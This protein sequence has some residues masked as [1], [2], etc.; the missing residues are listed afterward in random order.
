MSGSYAAS[1]VDYETL[2]AAKRLALGAA[3]A[4]ASLG[5][6]RGARLDA[7]FFGEPAALLRLGPLRLGFVL[8]C[9]GTKSLIASALERLT[10]AD[11]FAAIGFDTVA[12]AVN[13]CCCVGALPVLVNAYFASGAAEFYTGSRHRSLVEG[14]AAGCTAAGASWG[15][16][17]S[18]T[19]PGVVAPEAI[20]LAAAA[21][22]I[23]PDGAEPL[24]AARASLGPGNE[25]IGVSSSGLQFRTAPPSCAASPCRWTAGC[26]RRCR[27]GGASVRRRSIGASSTARSSRRWSSA[28]HCTTRAI[29]PATGCAS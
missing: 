18:P 29:S 10:G 26:S 7:S 14:F 24:S 25:I 16:G 20:D 21:V 8:E 4:T 9:L 15:G 12:A 13:D 17:E 22:G 19:L 28:G 2:D 3:R 5:A 27:R 6:A 1:G 11:H 23:V